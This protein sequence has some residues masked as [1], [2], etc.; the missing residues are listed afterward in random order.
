MFQLRISAEVQRCSM[1]IV[2]SEVCD[3][4][5]EWAVVIRNS[6]ATVAEEFGI[7]RENAPTNPAFA[8]ADSLEKMKEKGIMLYGAYLDEQRV[9]FV[10]IERAD[11]DRW[12]MERLAV[13]PPYRHRGIGRAL[14]DFAF[15]TVKKHGGKKVSIGIINENRVLK[16]WYMEYGFVE[17]GTRVFRHLPFEVC[18]M[19]KAAR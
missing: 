8:E 12:Y 11:G 18:F 6:F 10:A 1:D 17:T 4:F 14:M 3:K 19:E 7:T 9:G 5:E 2:I 13:L 16:N 15:K